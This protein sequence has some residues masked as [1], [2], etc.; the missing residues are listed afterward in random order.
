MVKV[1]NNYTLIEKV[2]SGN[3]GDVYRALNT[4]KLGEFAIKV[5]AA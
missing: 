1:I 3:Y 5:I 2:G 4:K